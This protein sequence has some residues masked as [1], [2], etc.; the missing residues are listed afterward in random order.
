MIVAFMGNDGSG[1]STLSQLFFR[2]LK[3]EGYSKIEYR[4]GFEY[5]TL[6]YILKLFRLK[7]L[8]EK[9]EILLDKKI[10]KKPLFFK[11][12]GLIWPLI[13]WF[14]Y[15]V[16]FFYANLLQPKKIIIFDRYA[17]DSL[18][19]WEYFGYA[20]PFLK[21]LYLIIPL[22]TICFILDAPGEVTFQRSQFDHKFSLEFYTAQR[23]RYLKYA[24]LLKIKVIS[25][26]K[27]L[28][29]SFEEIWSYWKKRTKKL[30]E[31]KT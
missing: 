22:P 7:S 21:W 29:T 19:G 2:K 11:I 8:E 12:T 14:D 4:R 5:F 18:V 27:S 17:I 30:K 23:E 9:R 28:N 25:T 3:E 20:N 10:K 16:Y 13:V 31:E 24:E 6:K 1:K 26:D 15:L